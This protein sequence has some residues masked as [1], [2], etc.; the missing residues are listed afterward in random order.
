MSDRRI[1]LLV[2]L[3]GIAFLAVLW[4]ADATYGFIDRT[5]CHPA[6]SCH[7]LHRIDRR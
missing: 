4:W 6:A 5:S 3:A 1:A 2:A 7:P